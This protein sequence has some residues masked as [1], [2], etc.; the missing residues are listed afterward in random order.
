[1]VVWRRERWAGNGGSEAMG[2][3]RQWPPLSES[4][5]RGLGAVR[6]VKLT[7]GAHVV[8][9]FVQI[10]QTGSNFKLKISA[11]YCSNNSQCLHEAGLGYY[12]QFPQLCRRPITN[13]NRAKNPWSDSTFEFFMNFKRNLN[14][15]EKSGKFFKILSWLHLHKSEFS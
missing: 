5:R 12:E 15:L 13:I 9:Y 2:V 4:G 14:L 3:A 8:L 10:I 7:L 11:L 6:A 1:M